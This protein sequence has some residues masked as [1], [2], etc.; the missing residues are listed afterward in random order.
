MGEGAV[1]HLR[2]D[3][4]IKKMPCDLMSS[5]Q[6]LVT[7]CETC[8]DTELLDLKGKINSWEMENK[9]VFTPEKMAAALVYFVLPS[10][11]DSNI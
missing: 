8:Y 5:R 1:S 4:I 3:R 7:V 2:Y 9:L 11:P 10:F 6:T